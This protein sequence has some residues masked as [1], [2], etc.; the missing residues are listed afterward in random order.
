MNNMK[1][2]R[3]DSGQLTVWMRYRE[4]APEGICRDVPRIG[5]TSQVQNSHSWVVIYDGDMELDPPSSYTR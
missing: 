2:A 3:G 4:P 1:T 5:P